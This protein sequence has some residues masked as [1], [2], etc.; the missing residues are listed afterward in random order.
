MF[1]LVLE[2]VKLSL[3][4]TE[5]DHDK[6]RTVERQKNRNNEKEEE[7]IFFIQTKIFIVQNCVKK[8]HIIINNIVSKT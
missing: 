4:F 7:L 2:C 6:E 8:R 5:T 3:L 1:L